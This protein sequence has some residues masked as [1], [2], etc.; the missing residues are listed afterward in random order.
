MGEG[1]RQWLFNWLSGPALQDQV[2]LKEPTPRHRVPGRWA[3][4]AWVE[5]LSQCVRTLRQSLSLSLA[6]TEV[7]RSMRHLLPKGS[8]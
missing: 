4:V 5:G 7:Y 1:L 8:L 2:D 3:A 6:D